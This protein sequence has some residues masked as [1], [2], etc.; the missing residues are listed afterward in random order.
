MV[1]KEREEEEGGNDA[2]RERGEESESDG[3]ARDVKQSD[4][5]AEREMENTRISGL[6][7]EHFSIK[8]L[9]GSLLSKE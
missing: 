9:Q 5:F 3:K 1:D 7:T 2:E 8:C 6:F 4:G